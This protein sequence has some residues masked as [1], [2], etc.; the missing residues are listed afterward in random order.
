MAGDAFE[1]NLE[2]NNRNIGEYGIF[3]LVPQVSFA[4]RAVVS[5]HS[6]SVAWESRSRSQRSQETRH[7]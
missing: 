2:T 5:R 1:S 4:G 6:C 3:V 7:G